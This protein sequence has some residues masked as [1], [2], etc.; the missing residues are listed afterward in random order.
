MARL[1]R[2][3]PTQDCY[4]CGSAGPG[5]LCASCRAAL[6][7]LPAARC[8]GCALPSTDSRLCG[9]CL[10]DKPHY[11]AT[12]AALAYTYPLDAAIQ[13]YKYQGSLGLS[14]TFV[15]LMAQA[16]DTREQALREARAEVHRIDLVLAMPLSTPRLAERGYNQAHEL[17]RRLARQYRLPLA[18]DAV[19]RHKHTVPQAELPW[20]ERAK[21]IRGAYMATRRFDGLS[22][23]V[24]DDV[25]TTGSTLSELARTLKKAG[26]THVTNW[27]LARALPAAMLAPRAQGS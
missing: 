23:A 8:P 25:M 26:A 24:V 16:I 17:A 21:N 9:R 2:Q 6:P 10:A 4:F 14:H 11:D 27:V 5:P 13:A 3:L 18:S 15:A 19:L 22:I 12:V 20:K 1:W 7:A